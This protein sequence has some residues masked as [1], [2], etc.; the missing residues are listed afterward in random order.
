MSN[1]ISIVKIS[2][3]MTFRGQVGKKRKIKKPLIG[4]LILIWLGPMVFAFSKI[5][6]AMYELFET[7]GQGDAI[8]VMGLLVASM[9]VFIFGIF[10][11]ISSYYMSRD[12]P[13]YLY[14]PLKPWEIT[15]ARFVIV[16]LYE[17]LTMLIFF[18]PVI[19]GFGIAAGMGVAYYLLSVLVFL[20][21]PILPL[22]LASIIIM[23]IMSFAKKAMN[24]D[25]FTMIASILGL[26]IGIGI[27]IGFQ[28]LARS[29]DN[30]DGLQE[31][32]MTGKISMAENIAK[33][34]PGIPNAAKAI[35]DGNILHLLIFIAIAV[36]AF[37]VFLVVAKA[38]YF[39]GVIGIN[40]Q[41]SRRE[42]DAK[43][44]NGFEAGSPV[45]TYVIKEL[46]LIFRTP[47]FFMNLAIIDFLLP[48]MILG[49]IFMSIDG[50]QI[51]TLKDT[52][53]LN[54][55]N[56]IFVGGAFV[57]FMFISAMNGVTATTISREG[58][59]FQI[60]KFIPMSYK[61][62]MDAK[63]ITGMV[64]SMIS[65]L[66]TLLVLVIYLGISI[67]VAVLMFIAAT[68]AVILTRLTGFLI[69]AA[70]PKLKW[71]NE[72][73]AVK[74]NMNL[75]FNMLVGMGAAG[76]AVVFLIFVSQAVIVNALVFIIV[77]FIVNFGLYKLLENRLPK[78]LARVE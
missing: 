39:R 68:N 44:S 38:I 50:E 43:K 45:K 33:Y 19:I 59:Q 14:M 3:A 58:K 62:Q 12:I 47:I 15:S 54:A 60:M 6:N 8:I 56:G 67:L 35:I 72:V 46:K 11:T 4:L 55:P 61:A 78:M 63:L 9:V 21:L 28:S 70:N 26:G 57:M 37:T 27:N 66:V 13:T 69:D 5:I 41:V 24:K 74:Q 65:M 71:D 30:Q 40:Q 31:L 25:R 75:L 36:A 53:M 16:L 42:F 77:M 64:I 10:Y 49:S 18:L 29:A 51:S 7:F 52:V 20:L 23:G 22:S 76:V 32:L 2:L 73:R 48:V 34:F 1:I 17:Y